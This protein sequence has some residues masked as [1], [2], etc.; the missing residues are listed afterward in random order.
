MTARDGFNGLTPKIPVDNQLSGAS[1]V[2]APVILYQLHIALVYATGIIEMD[3]LE[4]ECVQCC[5][6]T[7][8]G[9]YERCLDQNEVHDCI[10]EKSLCGPYFKLP[11]GQAGPSENCS[12]ASVRH[13]G[14]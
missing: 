13:A 3:R 4:Y 14:I 11:D 5:D 12:P 6:L 7:D 1:S 10:T 9:G 8:G 2:D